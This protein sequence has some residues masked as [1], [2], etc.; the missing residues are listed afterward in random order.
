MSTWMP[1]P[2]SLLANGEAPAPLPTI[3]T[4]TDSS[5]IWSAPIVQVAAERC[6]DRASPVEVGGSGRVDEPALE[7]LPPDSPG[8][9]AV[10]GV[11][12]RPGHRV[13][14]QQKQEVGRIAVGLV[15]PAGHV[16]GGHLAVEVGVQLDGGL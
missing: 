11:D 10:P 16:P 9:A 5:V 7:V 4:A 1:A 2:T 14:T 6:L 13:P 12:E 15:V 3:T 8:V